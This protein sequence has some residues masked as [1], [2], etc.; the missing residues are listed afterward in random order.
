[1]ALYHN[2]T[3]SLLYKKGLQSD[4]ITLSSTGAMVAYSGKCNGRVPKDKRIVYENAKLRADVIK[5]RVNT[6]PEVKELKQA[7]I[8][9]QIEYEKQKLRL[10]LNES[11][12][13]MIQSIIKFKIPQYTELDISK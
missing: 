4:R 9:A 12:K 8:Q 6:D 5:A 3:T 13:S 7:D 2:P 11:N 1:M 10:K